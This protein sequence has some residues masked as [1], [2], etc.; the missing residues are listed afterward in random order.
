MRTS[1]AA[2]LLALSASPAL[3]AGA[4]TDSRALASPVLAAPV[5]ATWAANHTEHFLSLGF[6]GFVFQGFLDDLFARA[7][8]SPAAEQNH[9]PDWRLR[10]DEARLALIQLSRA[11]LDSNH[12]HVT[13]DAETPW[14]NDP[15]RAAALAGAFALAGEFCRE[16]GL[17]GV[18]LEA[19]GSGLMF[20][21]DW[22]GYPEEARGGLPAAASDVILRALRA[23]YRAHP[24][25]GLTLLADAPEACGPLWF[26]FFNGVAASIGEADIPLRVVLRE[27]RMLRDPA[28]LDRELARMDR[29]AAGTLS[30]AN[31]TRWRASGG[32]C[33]ALDPVNPSGTVP[34]PRYSVEIFRLLRASAKLRS[35]GHFFVL[36]PLGGWWGTPEAEALQYAHLKQGGGGAVRPAPPFPAELRPFVMSGPFDG[37]AVV[38]GLEVQGARAD[39]LSSGRGAFIVAWAGLPEGLQFSRRRGITTSV[40]L[41]DEAVLPCAPKD[42]AVTVPPVGRPAV[43]GPLPPLE[44]ALPSALRFELDGALHPGAV[45]AGA[46]FGLHNPTGAPLD[47]GLLLMP[48]EHLSAGRAEAR[49]SLP[50]FQAHVEERI[51]QGVARF[52]EDASFSV[53]FLEA[54]RPPVSRV[55]TVP[56]VPE[57]A[58]SVPCDG[59]LMGAPAAA[60]GPRPGDAR[61]YC[62]SERGEA[63]CV[64]LEG[65]PVWKRRQYRFPG[66]NPPAAVWSLLGPVVALPVMDG[67]QFLDARG[68]PLEKYPLD[69]GQGCGGLAPWVGASPVEAG[70]IVLRRDG[71]L[72]RLSPRGGAVWRV[73][74]GLQDGRLSVDA[75]N[76]RIY[77]AGAPGEAGGLPLLSVFTS[78]GAPL[79]SAELSAS[80]VSEPAPTPDG[81]R[82]AAGLADGHV[83]V[84]STAS[85]D[86]L[87]TLSSAAGRFP[88]FVFAL[89]DPRRPGVTVWVTADLG[90][91][92]GLDPGARGLAWSVDLDGVVSAAA[93]PNRLGVV[94]GLSDGGV[95]CVDSTGGV[96]WRDG[97]AW[98]ASVGVATAAA[99]N[100]RGVVL[101][102]SRDRLLRA[103]DAGPMASPPAVLR[104]SP[105]GGVQFPAPSR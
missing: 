57:L 99:P 13:L 29:M 43:V 17:R 40:T 52:G 5:N 76:R 91:V 25:G 30:P 26:P 3:C 65:R 100:G 36:S 89:A 73:A 95:A 7:A 79:W 68:E 42:G 67:L 92:S 38:G 22:D 50:P 101:T 16:T 19:P 45:R 27:S 4:D 20:D 8:E 59:I 78:E 11:G 88:S 34:A 61:V 6:R 37:C 69:Y 96:L 98:G 23:Y 80:P 58:W 94:A 87:E 47:G 18:F 21:P 66:Q 71:E 103:L 90:G 31:L 62:I 93:L 86:L 54:D 53:T 32:W 56:V 28:S 60:F 83:F 81:A 72:A 74:T 1:V 77:A 33:L 85:G 44:H 49:I 2:I 105:R 84:F 14:F 39:I 64:D 12:L 75:G 35:A 82:V 9:P 15:A 97:R 48:P 104:E 55:F 10:V 102:T 24:R 51:V 70:F 46:R 41:E 63:V